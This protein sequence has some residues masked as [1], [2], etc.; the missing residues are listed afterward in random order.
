[1]S[2]KTLIKNEPVA[3]KGAVFAV[4]ASGLLLLQEFGVPISQGQGVAIGGFVAATFAVL[5]LVLRSD[6]TPNGKVVAQTEGPIVVAGEASPLPT[7]L[8]V[9]DPEPVDVE[10][11]VE[12]R[13][14]DPE[15]VL[16]GE[17]PE[18]YVPE[19]AATE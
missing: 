16:Y 3:V 2:I 14:G 18:G 4:G 17:T 5:V 12:A 11:Y 1:M 19:R 15:G 13:R 10:R 8:P 7:G 6:V 9:K